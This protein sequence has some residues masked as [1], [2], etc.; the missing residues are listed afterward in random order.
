MLYRD[1]KCLI[2]TIFVSQRGNIYIKRNYYISKLLYRDG[3]F[4][5]FCYEW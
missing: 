5:L 1:I 2:F 4:Q 3:Y